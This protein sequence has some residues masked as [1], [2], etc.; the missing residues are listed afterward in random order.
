MTDGHWA[1]MGAIWRF[2]GPPLR[3]SAQD[4]ALFEAA[5]HQWQKQHAS[6]PRALILGVTPELYSLRWPAGT[7]L[8]ALDASQQMVDAVWLGSPSAAV[9]GSWTAIPFADN[10][11]DIVV[12]DGGF[13]MLRYPDQQAQLLGELRRVLAVDGIFVVR[14]FSPVGRTGSTAS[15]FADL[16]AGKIASL[17][18][19]KLRLWGAL[20]GEPTVGVQPRR[21]VASIREAVGEFDQLATRYGWALPHVRA[22]EFH[23]DSM[24][25][26]YLTEAAEVARLAGEELGGFNLLDITE[27]DY[28]LGHCCPIVT[29][30]RRG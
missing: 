10:S 19:L 13:G 18:A 20:H 16:A 21:V 9:I 1:R 26:Y 6:P 23:R 14:L 30:Q 12:L 29:L 27:P 15:I 2:V 5:I 4:G 28:E 24:A 17:D 3:P 22:L 11:L 25:T 8:K 7:T